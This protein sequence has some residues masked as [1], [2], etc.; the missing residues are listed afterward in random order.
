ML[1][2]KSFVPER[3]VL[4]AGGSVYIGKINGKD[5][6]VII[7]KQTVHE[8]VFGRLVSVQ[9]E[10]VQQN[11]IYYS[12]KADAVM[13]I[14]YRIVYPASASHIIKYTSREV[15]VRET[16]GEYL[17]ILEKNRIIPSHWMENVLDANA[18][19]KSYYSDSEFMIIPD[20]TWD[21]ISLQQMHLLVLFKDKSLRTVREIRECTVL[22]RMHEKVLGVLGDL[23]VP[24]EEAFMY[25]HYRPTYYRLHLHVI[26]IRSDGDITASAMRAIPFFD[27][28]HNVRLCPEYYKRDLYVCALSDGQQS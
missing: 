3:K 20:Y 7:P 5:A 23:G 27:V 19:E 13:P 25:F 6:V 11:D 9:S 21:G 17:E 1:S 12:Y 8:D 15:Y 26:N 14:S 28:L 2:L 4:N 10:L 22:E 24:E 16:Y 18:E